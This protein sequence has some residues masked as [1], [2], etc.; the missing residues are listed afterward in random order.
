MHTPVISVI[1]PFSKEGNWLRESVQ[2]ILQQSFADFELLLTA[3]NSDSTTL[4][5]ATALAT[6]DTRIRL[7]NEEG[8]HLGKLLNTIIRNARGQYIARMDADDVSLPDRLMKQYQYL[9]SHPLTGLCAVAT[10][11]LPG[12]ETGEGFLQF[13]QWQNN[14]LSSEEHYHHRF[15]DAT[16]AHPAVMMRKKLFEEY[17]GYPEDGPED[18]GLWLHWQQQGVRFEKIPEMLLYWRDHPQRLSRTGIDYSPEAFTRV[19][20]GAA[21]FII[22]KY[23]SGKA[24]ILCGAGQEAWRKMKIWEANGIAFHG[25]SDVKMRQRPFPYHPPE[26]ISPQSGL[27]YISLLNG[28]G[29]ASE[30]RRFFEDKGLLPDHDFLIAS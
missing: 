16:V 20:A 5:I 18:F 4:S 8:H 19:K 3:N 1:L 24:V 11:T 25:Y 26:S 6:S 15:I 17:G 13:M 23:A 29:K 12:S 9:E 14:L 27:Y 21:A 22:D 30:M 10:G 28:R 7:T 2:S